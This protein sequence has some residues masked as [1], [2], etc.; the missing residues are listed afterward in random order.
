MPSPPVV[1]STGGTKGRND[2][3][4]Q[5]IACSLLLILIISVVT[6]IMAIVTLEK[7]GHPRPVGITIHDFKSNF[8]SNLQQQKHA[9]VPKPLK[10]SLIL[11]AVSTSSSVLVCQTSQPYRPRK[12]ISIK[13]M[14]TKSIISLWNWSM[15]WHGR[16]PLIKY[17]EILLGEEEN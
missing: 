6:T 10:Y 5:K 4:I 9:A 15:K 2:K 17:I 16:N 11:S 8:S 14:N 3:I 1:S 12:H 13:L 7:E